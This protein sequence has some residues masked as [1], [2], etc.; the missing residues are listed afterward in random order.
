MLANDAIARGAIEA[1][2]AVVACYP[3]TPSTEV[4]EALSRTAAER[5][6]YFEYSTNEKVAVEVRMTAKVRPGSAKFAMSAEIR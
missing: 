2:G 6:H 4:S 5:G 3:G 1:G